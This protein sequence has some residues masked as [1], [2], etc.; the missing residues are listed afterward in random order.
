MVASY[1]TDEYKKTTQHMIFVES[2]DEFSS[3]YLSPARAAISLLGSPSSV[4]VIARLLQVPPQ[5]ADYYSTKVTLSSLLHSSPHSTHHTHRLQL[6]NNWNRNRTY[7]P[8]N[9]ASP[10]PSQHQQQPV[11]ILLPIEHYHNL[12]HAPY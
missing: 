8:L 11:C 10:R 7:S 5:L 2:R 9:S 4:A 12:R 1:T 6:N 3:R